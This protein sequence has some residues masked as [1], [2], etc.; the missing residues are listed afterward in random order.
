MLQPPSPQWNK[1][2]PSPLQIS[3]IRMKRCEIYTP[4]GIPCEMYV[5]EGRHGPRKEYLLQESMW[6]HASNQQ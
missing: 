6:I 4:D 1:R 5:E 3:K 2:N